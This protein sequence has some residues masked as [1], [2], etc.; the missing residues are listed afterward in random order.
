MLPAAFAGAAGI[1]PTA[2]APRRRQ[3]FREA[4]L[5][6][7]GQNPH[8]ALSGCFPGPQVPRPPQARM[9]DSLS[10]LTG[11]DSVHKKQRAGYHWQRCS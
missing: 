11:T 4:E 3:K 1:I 9:L 5:G 8:Q 7:T 2:P 10:E 6:S